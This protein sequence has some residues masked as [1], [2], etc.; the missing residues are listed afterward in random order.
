MYN[1]SPHGAYMRRLRQAVVIY[2][3]CHCLV[4]SYVR[5]SDQSAMDDVGWVM[6]MGLWDEGYALDP[7]NAAYG[8][9]GIYGTSHRTKDS[10]CFSSE[11]C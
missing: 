5:L 4:L 1:S 6:G 10:H 11:A 7:A 8:R 2:T 9:S 3:I